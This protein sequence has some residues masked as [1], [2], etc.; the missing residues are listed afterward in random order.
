MNYPLLTIENLKV[1]YPIPKNILYPKPVWAVNDVS[2]HL[3]YGEKLALVGESG[4]G[5]SS[6]GRCIMGLLPAG[7]MVEGAVNFQGESVLK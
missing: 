3:N 1:A 5:K 6:L 7:S 4:C 2:F